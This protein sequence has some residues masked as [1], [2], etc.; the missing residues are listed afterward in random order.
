MGGTLLK[1][2]KPRD[3]AVCER[4]RVCV[5]VKAGH[6]LQNFNRCPFS[7]ILSMCIVIGFAVGHSKKYMKI[8]CTHL[9]EFKSLSLTN[10]NTLYSWI[11][12]FKLELVELSS[13]Y[14]SCS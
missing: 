5:R 11:K 3:V 7:C 8:Q 13:K 9:L 2:G 6:G 1:P 14:I 12:L 4:V 10:S